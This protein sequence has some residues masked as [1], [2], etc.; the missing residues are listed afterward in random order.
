MNQFGV[1]PINPKPLFGLI[2]TDAKS[3]T[4]KFLLIGETD[5]CKSDLLIKI[6][7]GNNLGE[8]LYSN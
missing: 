2:N 5:Q 7:G 3:K 8:G 1:K 6:A 4:Y